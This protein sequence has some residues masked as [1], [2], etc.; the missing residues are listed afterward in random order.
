MGDWGVRP[1]PTDLARRYRDEGWWND[2]TVGR[3]LAEGLARQPDQRLLF[4]SDDRPYRGTFADGLAMAQRVAGALAARGVRPGDP[5]AFQLPNQVEAAA[6]FWGAALLGAV[7][8]PIV[9]FYGAKEVG[10]ILRQSQARVLVTAAGTGHLDH[11]AILDGLAPDL[12]A[13]EHV[14]V[15]GDDAGRW[16]GFADAVD[17]ATPIVE[18]AAVDAAAPALIAYTSGTTADPK[19]VVHSHRTLGAEI[20]Q[21]AALQP[22]HGRPTLTG[23]PVGHAIG[24]LGGL[25]LPVFRGEP[26]AMIDGWDPA[27]ILRLMLEHDLTAGSGSTYFLL[28]L[29]EH[30]EFGDAHV[31]HMP[32]IGLGGS[33]VPAAIGE[34]AA[35]LGIETTR[36]YG[37]TEHPSTT[38]ARHSEPRAKRITTD[39]RPLAGVELCLDEDG[40]IW[41]RGPDL[42]SGYTDPQLTAEATDADGWYRTGDV[43]VLDDEGWLTIT[44]RAKDVI[45]R[46]G[47]NISPAEV[48]DLL[49]RMPGVAE[50]AVVAAPDERLGEHGCAFIRPTAGMAAPDLE[51]IRA[52]LE[53]A[54]LAR[55]KWPEEIREVADLP[56]TAT[57]KIQKFALRDALRRPD[58]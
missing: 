27:T 56:R 24:M 44:D 45:I 12:P 4:F 3:V 7:A 22:D 20:R 1:V 2:D 47:E 51:A 6:T 53:A 38:G 19:G 33:A 39:G 10:Y 37:S 41:S 35:G 14:L 36:A 26:I 17:A 31:R 13:L 49:L 5:V 9:H 54:G 30:P 25:L 32:A 21:L 28:S 50:V 34:R 8:V 55:Q 58:A 46:G 16:E 18:L 29:L 43:G 42:F 57:G 52:H 40:E 48:E 11:L 15:V 23:A